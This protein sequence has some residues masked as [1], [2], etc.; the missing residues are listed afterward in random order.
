MAFL[1]RRLLCVLL[2]AV[3]LPAAP[4]RALSPG[5]F[6]TE[7]QQLLLRAR[8]PLLEHGD[9]AKERAALES[10][11]RQRAYSPLWLGASGALTAQASGLLQAMRAADELGLDPHLYEATRIADTAAANSSDA[12]SAAVDLALSIMA[13]R[14]ATH[15]HFGQVDPKTA[16]FDMPQR[17]AMDVP[18]L[19]LRLAAAA[20]IRT[21]LASLEPRFQHYRLLKSSLATYREL[22]AQPPILLPPLPTKPVKPGGE[23]SGAQP[24]RQLLAL[25]GDLPAAPGPT[26]GG[27]TL[28]ETLVEG[29]KRFQFRHGLQQDGVL[30]SNTYAELTAP[31]AQRVRQIELTLERWRWLPELDA[32][33]IIVNIP[34][35]RLF[36][37]PSSEDSE[38]N[39]VTM[40]VIVGTFPRTRTPAFAADMKFVKFR[41]YWDVPYSI[42]KSELLPSIRK[43]A[44]Y[45]EQHDM[46]I[47]AGQD[48]RA[49][50]L[51]PTPEVIEQLAAGKLRLRQKPGADNPLGQVKFMLPNNYNI[52]LHSTPAR[53]LFKQSRRAFSHGCIRV[54]NPAALAEY[55]LRNA[56]GDWTPEKIE[57]A[58]N[59]ADN[60]RVDLRQWIR[61]LIVY[62][63]AVATEAGKVYFFN[64][65]Y[66]NDARLAKL[67]AR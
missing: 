40:D 37:F 67:L 9:L 6:A 33:T 4:A 17:S 26:A 5:G 49:T 51:A 36:A 41:P 11:Y 7:L 59:G 2:V 27:T 38:A 66:G 16:A 18:Q 21:E 10:L 50:P 60:Q 58:M 63:T 53:E 44:A 1:A 52:Y 30:G 25:L 57:A 14:F 15:L 34:Q 39:M 55:V 56:P 29:L 20:D 48:D 22:A 46:E 47:V 19:L 45:L 62:G 28:D 8:H 42:M 32:P 54:S 31:L 64:D 43:N 24:L 35:F 12:S 23:Y 61:V 13:V 65:I 3:L